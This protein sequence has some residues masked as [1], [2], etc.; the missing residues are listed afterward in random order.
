MQIRNITLSLTSLCNISCEYC[1][2]PKEITPCNIDKIY[3]TIAAIYDYSSVT[4][5]GGEPFLLKNEVKSII[6]KLRSNNFVKFISI[7]T[8]GT[9]YDNDLIK[10]LVENNVSIAISHDGH[11]MNKRGN[12]KNLAELE[13]TIL[14][15]F[16]D[17]NRNE[18]NV[19]I[20]VT[21]PI[22][23]E[24]ILFENFLSIK[25]SIPEIKRYR[26]F[27]DNRI[28]EDCIKYDHE[29]YISKYCEEYAKIQEFM[30]KEALLTEINKAN[31]IYGHIL[32]KAIKRNNGSKMQT[33]STLF[34]CN[35]KSSLILPDGSIHPCQRNIS[36]SSDEE[37]FKRCSIC[38]A[39]ETEKTKKIQEL[40]K[41]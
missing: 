31:R 6:Q 15:I 2:Y 41:V 12:S 34:N 16:N 7:V 11:I 3:D 24:G 21:V 13:N 28:V 26:F 19:T 39:L 17:Y 18:E 4:I 22:G 5:L 9:I 30:Y 40:S 1:S 29:E 35:M 14:K 37:M 23:N 33:N 25:N 27:I 36:P 8:N 32:Y 20:Y 10:F 38:V